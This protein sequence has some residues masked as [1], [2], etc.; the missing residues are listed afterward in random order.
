MTLLLRRDADAF[1][2]VTGRDGPAPAPTGE[3]RSPPVTGPV[4]AFFYGPGSDG[5]GLLLPHPNRDSSPALRRRLR[6]VAVAL[7]ASR[8]RSRPCRGRVPCQEPLGEASSGP[9]SNP[10]SVPVS[11]EMRRAIVCNSSFSPSVFHSGKDWT[12]F[13]AGAS[14]SFSRDSWLS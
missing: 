7:R 14:H 1:A 4:R 3:E 5:M 2:R 6:D 12:A 10:L 11:C 8:R 9:D 13:R